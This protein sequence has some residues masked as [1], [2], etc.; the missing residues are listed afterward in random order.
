MSHNWKT[1]L[2]IDAWQAGVEPPVKFL[3]SIK[4]NTFLIFCQ[5]MCSRSSLL[6]RNLKKISLSLHISNYTYTYLKL[7]TCH[8]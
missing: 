2:A 6:L 1:H 5:L 8:N 4:F 3:R 7:T